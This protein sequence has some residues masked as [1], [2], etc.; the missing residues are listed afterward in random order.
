[1]ALT[2][3]RSVRELIRVRQSARTH[4]GQAL[5]PDTAARLND[6]CRQLDRGLAGE[7]ARFALVEKPFVKGAKVRLGNY[8]LQKNPRYFFAG[9]VQKSDLT[10]QSYGY[11]MEQL[12]L[13][14]T[15]LGLGTCWIGFFDRK[16]FADFPVADDEIFP[17]TCT[18]G[19]PADRRLFEKISRAAVG[20]DKRKN[21][22]TLFF[23][24]D[25]STPLA[26]TNDAPHR[27]ILEMVRLA[28]SSG[29][30]QPW[31][32]VKDNKV[33]AWHFFM[34]KVRSIY[35]N[36]GLHHIDL[37]IAMCHFELTAGELGL[38]GKWRHAA[39][40]ISGLPENTFYTMSWVENESA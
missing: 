40:D 37:G 19:H 8:G 34:K 12:V 25:F 13:K 18:V 10:R 38:S 21:W 32:I 23:E 27:E 35:F 3:D 30:S 5:S 15:E 26:V 14:A 29:N 20:A 17:A 31:R 16:F 33:P 7:S 36:A 4:T 9:A 6:A 39:P 22:Q 11:L 24:N 28:P 1:M 2:Y